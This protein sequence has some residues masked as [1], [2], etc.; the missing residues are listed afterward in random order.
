MRLRLDWPAVD[1]LVLQ[2]KHN[3]CYLVQLVYF[4]PE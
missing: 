3:V 4:C 1:G 2:E